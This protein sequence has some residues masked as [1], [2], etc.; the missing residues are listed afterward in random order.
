VNA[1]EAIG[2]AVRLLVAFAIAYFFDKPIQELVNTWSDPKH[3][4]DPLHLATFITA[5]IATILLWVI[6]NFI[7]ARPS[8]EV[9]WTDLRNKQRVDERWIQINSAEG[10]GNVLMEFKIKA[11]ATSVLGRAFMNFATGDERLSV[12]IRFSKKLRL[13]RESGNVR[14][15]ER[16]NAIVELPVHSSEEDADWTSGRFFLSARDVV[17][18]FRAPVSYSLEFDG[19]KRLL[20]RY[21]DVFSSVKTIH[22]KEDL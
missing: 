18:N 3:P 22:L 16:V 12:R 11:T 14:I 17:A 2:D 4:A 15:A 13:A 19:K 21:V 7:G 10:S 1:K 6:L 9:I 20:L 5:V 8:A